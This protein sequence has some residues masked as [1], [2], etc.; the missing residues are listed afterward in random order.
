MYGCYGCYGCYGWG[1]SSYAPT[2]MPAVPS[3]P[4][5]KK[6]KKDEKKKDE[7][8]E[9]AS[10]SARAR[11]LVQVPADAKLYIDGRLMK[12]TSPSRVFTTP[13][14]QPGQLYFYEV[15]AE[16]VR[17]GQVVRETRR[18]LVRSGQDSRAVFADPTTPVAK[19]NGAQ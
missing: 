14:L 7:T 19:K 15:R 2:I 9:D 8:K 17:D 5:E 13:V 1:G 11:L 6:D 3:K 10:A 18:V 4:E 12:S 16:M